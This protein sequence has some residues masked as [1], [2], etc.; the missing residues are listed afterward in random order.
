MQ[1]MLDEVIKKGVS[2][3]RG[4]EIYWNGKEWLYTDN[5]EPLKDA[6]VRSC[7]KCGS[8]KNSGDGDVDECLGVLPG[9]TNACCGQ[10]DPTYSYVCFENG[11]V[12]Q[13]FT[14]REKYTPKVHEGGK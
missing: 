8:L 6:P 10:G 13:G 11:V 5:N 1:S 2:T 12:L 14:V 3:C 7:K 4:H 9:V